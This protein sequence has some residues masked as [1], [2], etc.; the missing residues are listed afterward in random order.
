MARMKCQH[1]ARN[2]SAFVDGRLNA[3]DRRSVAL[4]LEECQHC[5]SLADEYHRVRQS[6]RSIPVVAPPPE[7][8]TRLRIVASRERVRMATRR[9]WRA[10]AAGWV[11]SVNLWLDN[12]MYPLALP[13]AGGVVS[14]VMLFAV[15]VSG[16]GPQ[17]FVH[18]EDVLTVLSTGASVRSTGPLSYT[19][20]VEV[21]I[22]VDRTGRVVDYTLPPGLAANPELRRSLENNLIFTQFYPATTFG[23]PTA[24]KVRLSFRKSHIEVKG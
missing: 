20:E 7:L 9:S 5:A 11:A 21:D 2:M 16:V 22:I 18:G 24:G 15:L 10:V 4:H 17:A 13:F 12:L 3:A 1:A 14:A 19:D 8:T 23:L 6:L